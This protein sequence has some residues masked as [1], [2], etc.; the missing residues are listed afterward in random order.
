MPSQQP[1][2]LAK[3]LKGL[4]AEG[5]VLVSGADGVDDPFRCAP[6]T[7]AQ[8]AALA[9]KEGAAERD[10][11]AM[12]QMQLRRE[13]EYESSLDAYKAYGRIVNSAMYASDWRSHAP[14]P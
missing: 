7:D 9:L 8:A 14:A 12:S 11:A 6:L 10:A 3:A 13:W 5:W 2:S 4:C 1:D